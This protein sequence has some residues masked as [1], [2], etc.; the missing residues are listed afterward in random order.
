MNG[1]NIRVF[2]TAAIWLNRKSQAQ[3]KKHATMENWTLLFYY[4]YLSSALLKCTVT[5][6]LYPFLYCKEDQDPALVLPLSYE[7]YC[8]VISFSIQSRVLLTTLDDGVLFSDLFSTPTSTTILSW[9]KLG[10]QKLCTKL[11][12]RLHRISY[13][14]GLV[15]RSV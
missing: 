6:A 15:L 5:V 12:P 7:S 1:Y 3:C 13:T 11:Y 2:N 4:F 14:E 8:P 9:S 10:S